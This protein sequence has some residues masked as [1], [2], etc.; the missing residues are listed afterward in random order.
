MNKTK[1]KKITLYL[2]AIS[3]ISLATLLS[4]CGG[5]SDESSALLSSSEIELNA[6]IIDPGDGQLY[7]EVDLDR[8]PHGDSPRE[9]IVLTGGDSL[10]LSSTEASIFEQSYSDDI[11]D[12]AANLENT[13]TKFVDSNYG[14]YNSYLSNNGYRAIQDIFDP[15]DREY[16]ITLSRNSGHNLYKSTINLAEQFSLNHNHTSG[17]YSRSN[18]DVRLNWSFNSN[19]SYV[20]DIEVTTRCTGNGGYSVVWSEELNT[21]TTGSYVFQAG[22]LNSDFLTGQCSTS[23]TVTKTTIGLVSERFSSGLISGYTSRTLTLI[24]NE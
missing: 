12:Q 2:S 1:N 10:Y 7:A 23:F 13:H 3:A 24:A 4:A 15:K 20:I 17:Y 22:S 8:P 6:S 16:T 11:F 14:T 21:D 18:D 9:D 19:K 5:S